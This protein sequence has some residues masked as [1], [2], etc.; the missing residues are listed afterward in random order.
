[1]SKWNWIKYINNESLICKYLEYKRKK[2]DLIWTI[3]DLI[4]NIKN[5]NLLF[6]IYKPLKYIILIKKWNLFH[7]N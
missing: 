4:E 7:F 5:E 3:V 1:M 2:F 6:I